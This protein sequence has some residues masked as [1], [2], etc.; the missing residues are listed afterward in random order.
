M[1]WQEAQALLDG[2]W[3]SGV[4][5]SRF[6]LPLQFGAVKVF[7]FHF[8]RRKRFGKP[9]DEDFHRLPGIV[10]VRRIGHTQRL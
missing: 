2:G 5:T 1:P 7:D 4:V 3:L 9:F 10:Q 8:C 6:G